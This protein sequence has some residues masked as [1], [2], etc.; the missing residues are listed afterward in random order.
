MSAKEYNIWLADYQIE[1]WGDIRDDLRAASIVQ[2]N[3][4]PH[5]KKDIPLKD[6]MLNFE[7]KKKQTP[8][9]MFSM[10]KGHTIVMGGKVT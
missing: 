5:T 10:L 7:P 8:Q 4:M 3:L 6:C 1:P 9:E 2:S